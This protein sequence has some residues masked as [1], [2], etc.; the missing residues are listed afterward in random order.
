MGLHISSR[1][2]VVSGF[3]F[4]RWTNLSPRDHSIPDWVIA[5][6]IVLF[7]QDRHTGPPPKHQTTKIAYAD[8]DSEIWITISIPLSNE[9]EVMIM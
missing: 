1:S 8:W 7:I 3:G 5:Q 6:Y 9:V 2:A 4:I